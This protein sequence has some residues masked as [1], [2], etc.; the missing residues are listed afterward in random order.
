MKIQTKLM[1]L[2]A[3][4]AVVFASV[5]PAN[6]VPTIRYSV[7]GGMSIDVADQAMGVD[8][9][10]DAG[11]VSINV[12]TPVFMGEI[13]AAIT[14]PAAGSAA[15]PVMSLNISGTGVGAG[16]KTLEVWFTET[17]FGPTS[18]A[19]LTDL[20]TSGQ[21]SWM[22]T[23]WV[24]DSNVAFA[25]TTLLTMLVGS[26]TSSVGPVPANLPSDPFTTYSITTYLKLTL[27]G[28]VSA[29]GGITTRANL[30]DGGS[31]VAFLGMALVAVEGVR[32][33]F[34]KA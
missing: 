18:A 12:F 33:K 30:P 5:A 11:S 28:T 16:T 15:L 13:V 26:N 20:A 24:S 10:S 14:K 34:A 32:R 17:D 9:D 6:A 21:G 27:N 2:A 23:A 19:L 8:D 25:E 4:G 7:N 1:G 31:T 3:A 29:N 22:A